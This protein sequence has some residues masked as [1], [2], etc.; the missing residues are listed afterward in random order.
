MAKGNFGI[1]IRPLKIGGGADVFHGFRSG[2]GGQT[3]P[4]IPYVLGYKIKI[5]GSGSIGAT[6]LAA[7]TTQEFD[8]DVAFPGREFPNNVWIEE[9]YIRRIT[10]FAGGSVSAATVEGGDTGNDDELLTATSV[11]T[12]VGAGFS[13]T[14]GAANYALHDESSFVPTFTINTTT[15]NVDALTAGELDYVIRF[16][17]SI[18]ALP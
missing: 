15:D 12:G 16:R 8:L 14:T 17:P 1:K 2:I 4:N 10:D 13:R 9:A 6:A 7:A 11:F 5:D 3:M 18:P